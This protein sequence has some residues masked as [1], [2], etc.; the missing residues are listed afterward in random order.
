MAA[1]DDKSKS[2]TGGYSGAG[3][4]YAA[5]QAATMQVPAAAQV[6]TLQEPAAEP[7]CGDTVM[8]DE[9]AEKPLPASAEVVAPAPPSSAE[10]KADD[11]ETSRRQARTKRFG[12]VEDIP[13]R[14]RSPKARTWRGEEVSREIARLG[15]Y[16]ERRPKGLHVDGQKGMLLS[17]LVELWGAPKGL[18]RAEIM[19]AVREHTWHEDGS[20]RFATSVD[21]EGRI[22]LRVMPK[23]NR[24]DGRGPPRRD[25]AMIR[26]APGAP[27]T[28]VPGNIGCATFIGSIYEREAPRR[29]IPSKS[30]TS[31]EEDRLKARREE[32]L[33]QKQ[34]AIQSENYEAAAKARDAL[35]S[36]DARLQQL[37]SAA[38]EAADAMV[39]D[40]TVTDSAADFIPVDTPNAAVDTGAAAALDDIQKAQKKFNEGM[41]AWC[42]QHA[43]QEAKAADVMV[44]DAPAAVEAAA[45]TPA[46]TAGTALDTSADA[47]NLPSQA[48]A[49]SAEEIA[50]EE[51]ARAEAA[52]AEAARAEAARKEEERR[53]A[54]A[55]RFGLIGGDAEA[56][57]TDG[58]KQLPTPW[59]GSK[60]GLDNVMQDSAAIGPVAV[61]DAYSLPQEPA[62]LL[63]DD[64]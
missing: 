13:S 21:A 4:Y 31:E 63:I 45:A 55:K 2:L 16:P 62:V 40:L 64:A 54:R 3:G 15:R 38:A 49:R 48:V 12:A 17:E 52:R 10:A 41:A 30:A 47:A 8:Q 19:N 39:M 23:R 60:N 18:G 14:S 20:L 35:R 53:L 61:T 32:L 51:A 57:T 27:A 33:R 26:A 43:E 50:R 59:C 58:P 5:V 11:P 9:A 7:A 28:P 25:V 36:V 42:H 34:Q 24:E 37:A 6:A 22:L 56:S 46:E 1:E 29:A 44:T